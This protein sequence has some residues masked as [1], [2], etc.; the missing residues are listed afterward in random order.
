MTKTLSGEA[1]G[2]RAVADA[3]FELRNYTLRPGRRDELITLFERE[4][5]E[6]QERAGASILGTFR[7]ID[8]ADHFVWLRG[9][10]G[11]AARKDS[12]TAFYTGPVWQAHRD[13]AN[14]T[15]LDSDNVHL[16]H[17]LGGALRVA[18]HRP[19][20][21]AADEARS[22]FAIDT[23]ALA[24]RDENELARLAAQDGHAVATFATERSANNFPRLP[25]RDDVV[26]VVMR[27][28]EAEQPVPPV[29]DLPAPVVTLRLRP[30][31]RSLLR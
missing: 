31:R 5:V 11:M 21:T 30:T 27:R 19:G 16:L 9:F 3:I 18:A 26:L 24:G 7:D 14:A 12:L 4:F 17:R 8:A 6:S 29:S 10:S 22:M 25:V 13:S 23:Y 28:F 15:M 1:A 2:T 20:T